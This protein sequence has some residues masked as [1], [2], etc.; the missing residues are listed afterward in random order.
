MFIRK[1]IPTTNNLYP[2]RQKTQFGSLRHAK[3]NTTPLKKDL[4][5][6]PFGT[7]L[8]IYGDFALGKY[9]CNNY[10]RIKHKTNPQNRIEILAHHGITLTYHYFDLDNQPKRVELPKEYHDPPSQWLYND[11]VSKVK[12]MRREFLQKKYSHRS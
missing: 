11:I 6:N 1:I 10:H 4:P 7:L 2:N 8:E 3:V 9:Q 12:A 5:Q